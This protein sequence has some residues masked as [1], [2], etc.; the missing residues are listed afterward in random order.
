MLVEH[1]IG[2]VQ[3][4]SGFT[5]M[6][7][8]ARLW[9]PAL[10]TV[11]VSS[12]SHDQHRPPDRMRRF[13]PSHRAATLAPSPCAM[14]PSCHARAQACEARSRPGTP[15]WPTYP[16]F[17]PILP[18][19]AP[20]CAQL[21]GFSDVATATITTCSTAGAAVGFFVGGALGDALSRRRP[22]VARPAINQ[23]SILLQLPLVRV[24]VKKRMRRMPAC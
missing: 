8:Q 12:G 3:Y 10:D 24:L 20:T 11:G 16:Y 17:T 19:H 14:M 9:L 23:L 4:S 2:Y 13:V 6:Y 21:L 7:L 15:A 1:V 5:T 22:H 18:Y